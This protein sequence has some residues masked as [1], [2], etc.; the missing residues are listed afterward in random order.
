MHADYRGCC[1]L[2]ASPSLG[3]SWRGG[4][5]LSWCMDGLMI[6]EEVVSALVELKKGSPAA[7][8]IQRRNAVT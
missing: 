5:R 1:V 4:M 8:E 3:N 2:L 7:V 6:L